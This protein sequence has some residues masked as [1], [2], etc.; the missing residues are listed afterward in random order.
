MPQEPVQPQR[1]KTPTHC[2]S[3]VQVGKLRPEGDSRAA[4]PGGRQV[5]TQ[6]TAAGWLESG[7]ALGEVGKWQG[8]HRPGTP[9]ALCTL[10]PLG[11]GQYHHIDALKLLLSPLQCAGPAGNL[12][13]HQPMSQTQPY[14]GPLQPSLL[15]APPFLRPTFSL[16]N[17]CWY[18]LQNEPST[19]SLRQLP[20]L[21]QLG[22][23]RTAGSPAGERRPKASST[24][25]RQGSWRTVQSHWGDQ[26]SS[27]SEGNGSFWGCAV[28]EGHP[29]GLASVISRSSQ[30]ALRTGA[31]ASRSRLKR[32]E[33]ETG[34][35]RG[36]WGWAGPTTQGAILVALVV[37]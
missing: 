4:F 29:G 22:P 12:P 9:S 31:Q 3:L 25:I 26:G 27:G 5:S 37:T 23:L 6:A 11:G 24:P 33:A 34:R 21:L 8:I 28:L 30:E 16:T 17:S 1:A 18:P 7:A 19:H 14:P 35:P 32:R 2:G 15:K 36:W 20:S 13:S 10:M